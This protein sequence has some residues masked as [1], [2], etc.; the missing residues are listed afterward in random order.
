MRDKVSLLLTSNG[1]WYT[2]GKHE[3]GGLIM[4][5][6]TRIFL[7]FLVNNGFNPE[8]Y[9]NI[10]EIIQSVPDSLSKYLKYYPQFLLSEKVDY[11]ELISSQINGANGYIDKSGKMVVPKTVEGDKYFKDLA[12]RLNLYCHKTIPYYY[13]TVN[14][15]DS[16]I[17]YYDLT[18]EQQISVDQ[19]VNAS[20]PLIEDKYI[21]LITD[22]K[23]QEQLTKNLEI[24]SLLLEVI[25]SN[26]RYDYTM[27]HDT[28]SSQD[29]ELYLIKRRNHR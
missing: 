28:V 23:N 29:K 5:S 17:A 21:G 9:R 27:I 24:F 15:F 26:S 4:S 7:D 18:G 25:N 11:S 19:I 8:N 22:T 1:N 12:V 6:N 3:K 2:I 16:L 10:L 20:K 13:P 14:E